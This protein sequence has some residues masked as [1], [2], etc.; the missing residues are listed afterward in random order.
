VVTVES[1][2][3]KLTPRSQIDAL[4]EPRR[5]RSRADGGTESRKDM[6]GYCPLGV[7]GYGTRTLSGF[8]FSNILN[9]TVLAAAEFSETFTCMGCSKSNSPL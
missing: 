6:G 3:P 8:P 7:M 9:V 1:V 2:D 4:R 5:A